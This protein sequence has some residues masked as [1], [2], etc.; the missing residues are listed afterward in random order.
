MTNNRLKKRLGLWTKNHSKYGLWKSY[1]E[2]NQRVCSEQN[3]DD[4]EWQV[5]EIHNGSTQLEWIESKI[6]YAPTSSSTPFKAQISASGKLYQVLGAELQEP[7]QQTK[8]PNIS[9]EDLLKKQANW[10]QDLLWYVGFEPD[11]NILTTIDDTIYYHDKER[12]LLSVLD[13]S[14]KHIHNM[15]FGWVL[16]TSK[17]KRLVQSYGPAN[18]RGIL[19]RAEA[20]VMLSIS[21]FVASIAK[22]KD[23]NDLNI[24]FISD[25]KE[26]I[27]RSNSHFKYTILYPNATLAAEYDVT[28]QVF[29]THKTYG[30]TSTFAHV[31]GHQEKKIRFDKLPIEAQ[32]NC[33]V[34]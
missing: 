19:L 7:I 24:K 25:N 2:T 27:N 1:Q 28:E 12:F 13:G 8:G 20:V 6:D 9:F 26:L 18:E 32:L 5:Y 21:I 11:K 31:Y 23:R 33:R 15:S 29:L 30:T 3:L 34:D 16:T 10:I 17:G 22:Y 4:E 14:V